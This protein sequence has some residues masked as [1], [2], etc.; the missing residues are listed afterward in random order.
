MNISSSVYREVIG[1]LLVHASSWQGKHAVFVLLTL[2][3]ER[4]GGSAGG[5]YITRISPKTGYVRGSI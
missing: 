2:N 3:L 4:V 5:P 1:K